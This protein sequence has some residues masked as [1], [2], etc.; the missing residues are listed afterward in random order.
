MSVFS[1][2]FSPPCLITFVQH[3]SFSLPNSFP[4]ALN[5]KDPSIPGVFFSDI[6]VLIPYEELSEGF[7][8]L[9]AFTRSLPYCGPPLVAMDI[10]RFDNTLTCPDKSIRNYRK[11]ISFAFI[12]N[13]RCQSVRLLTFPFKFVVAEAQKQQC[14]IHHIKLRENLL[15]NFLGFP[16]VFVL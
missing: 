16:K 6:V 4:T 12:P 10:G 9:Q 5:S 1:L 3:N 7:R 11:C 2:S 15:R 14:D 13:G 8:L